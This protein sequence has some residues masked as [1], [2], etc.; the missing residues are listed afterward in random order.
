M[1]L[2]ISSARSLTPDIDAD[3]KYAREG[4]ITEEVKW[5]GG[6]IGGGLVMLIPAVCMHLSEQQSCFGMIVLVIFAVMG[7]AG[8]LYS[9]IVALY[10]VVNG[11]LCKV[12]GIWTTPFKNSSFTN[13]DDK[14][15]RSC[16]E[17]KNVVQFNIILFS[18]L[19]AISF[20]QLLLCVIQ[21]INGL[22]GCLFG[23]CINKE[24]G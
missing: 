3:A 12:N 17:P 1:T 4:H 16:T 7:G 19:M 24:E 11:P 2:R 10:G 21:I 5:L 15:W 20:L 9:F 14:Y 6:V 18:I 13:L 8:A 23:I 22:F